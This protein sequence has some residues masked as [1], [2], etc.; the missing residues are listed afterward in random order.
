MW[1]THRSLWLIVCVIWYV[2]QVWLGLSMKM[3]TW[4]KLDFWYKTWTWEKLGMMHPNEDWWLRGQ[5]GSHE[6]EEGNRSRV[7]IN[8]WLWSNIDKKVNSWPKSTLSQQCVF[9]M[10]LDFKLIVMTLKVFG[11]ENWRLN[12]IVSCAWRKIVSLQQLN[13]NEYLNLAFDFALPY[14]EMNLWFEHWIWMNYH[15][16]FNLDHGS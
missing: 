6:D 5:S 12:W 9:C 16:S 4:A 1:A 10:E 7:K 13:L 8:G 2:L 15:K 14:L 3:I 11:N